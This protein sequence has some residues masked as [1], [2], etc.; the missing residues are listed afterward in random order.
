VAG[1]LKVLVFTTVFPNQAQP[2]HGLFVAERIRHL[3]AHAAVRVVAP[4][5]WFRR[6]AAMGGPQETGVRVVHPAFYYVP[7]LCKWLDGLLLFVS[8]L[9]SVRT[10]RRQFDFDLIDAHFGYPDGVAAVLLGRWFRRPV[11]ITLRGSEIEMV[12]FRLR[13]MLTAWALRRAERV[14]AVSPQLA[15]LALDLGTHRDKVAVIG[16]GVDAGLFRPLD[17]APARRRLGIDPSQKLIVAVGHLAPV[18]GFD[19]FLDVAQALVAER[20][21]VRFAIVGG[22]AATSGRYA[23]RLAARIARM[24]LGDV[25]TVTGPVSRDVVA[26]WLNAAD[27]FVLSSEREGSPNGLREALACGCPV[28]ARDVGDVREVVTP[29]CGLVLPERAGA[30]RW[31]AAVR[32]A[33]RQSWDRAAIRGEAARLTWT[34]VAERVSRHWHAAAGAAPSAREAC[35]PAQVEL[36]SRDP[37]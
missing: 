3:T 11:T 9:W 10:L 16:N 33:L 27:L 19:R 25:L 8:A 30:E 24:R 34:G 4:V 31:R 26:C 37:A 13:R 18:K 1:E 7:G 35:S 21:D 29:A 32:G 36:E 12:R 28:V 23:E 22:A 6:R 2:L 17:R 14:I 20:P 15:S 5:A